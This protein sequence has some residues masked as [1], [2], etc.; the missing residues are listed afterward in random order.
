LDLKTFQRQF[1]SHYVLVG[2]AKNPRFGGGKVYR[3]RKSGVLVIQKQMLIPSG[4]DST[5]LIAQW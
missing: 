5:A 4:K 1:E 2:D 3:N